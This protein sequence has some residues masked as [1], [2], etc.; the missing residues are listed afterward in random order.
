MKFPEGQYDVVLADPPWAY[1]GS[2]DKWAAAGKFY[3]LMT[4]EEIFSLPV[5]DLLTPTGALFLWATGPSLETSVYA[6]AEWGLY[7]R[8]VGFVW[9]KT[10]QDGTPIGAQGVRPSFIKPL[11]EF[12]I[13]GSKAKRGRPMKLAS[14]A[15]SQTVFAPRREHSRKPVEVRER[16]EALFAGDLKKI[17]LFSRE[18]T[19]GWDH[20]GNERTKFNGRPRKKHIGA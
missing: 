6:L 5:G 14:E 11:T 1:Y 3:D 4:P 20:W 13:I 17:E 8:G 19:P 16:I 2:P 18:M 12:V 7:F 10:K 9:V 15:I